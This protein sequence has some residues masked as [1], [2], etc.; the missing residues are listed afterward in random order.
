MLAEA[1]ASSCM[2]KAAIVARDETEQGE[3]ALLNFGQTFAHA[4]ETVAGY[5][6]LLHGEAVAIGM[7]LAARLSAR[8]G[9]ATQTDADRLAA[10]LMRQQLPVT[11][12]ANLDADTLIA[13]MRLDK[14]NLSGRL[15]LILWRGIGHAEI[16]PDVDTTAIHEV[17]RQATS[18]FPRHP[19]ESRDPV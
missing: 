15:R 8:L 10:L 11:V 16:V 1:I 14:K 2:H 7:C 17:L 6:T 13:A 19:G 18:D 3:R 5:G 9:H 4:I 12:P